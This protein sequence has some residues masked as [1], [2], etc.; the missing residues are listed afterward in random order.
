MV[1]YKPLHDYGSSSRKLWVRPSRKIGGP[2]TG[3]QKP[4]MA[5]FEAADGM[6]GYVSKPISDKELFETIEELV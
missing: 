1:N 3:N 6:D 2:D 4:S 5:I